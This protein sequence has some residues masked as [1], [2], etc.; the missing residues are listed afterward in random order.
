[1]IAVDTN[2]LVAFQ[3]MEYPQ[4]PK[5]VEAVRALAEGSA[6]WA[7]PWPCLHEFLAIV[8]HPRIFR[9]PT[10][11]TVALDTLD[12]LIQSP[13]LRILSENQSYWPNLRQVLLD[14]HVQGPKVHDARIATLCLDH[15]VRELWT[16]DRD[17]SRFGSLKCRNPLL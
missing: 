16:A 12:A 6:F 3:R 10:P 9:V 15:N 13:T 7:I 5:A 11:M 14:S 2:I 8:T 4:H 17:F 1:M